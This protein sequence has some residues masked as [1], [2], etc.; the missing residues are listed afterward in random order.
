MRAANDEGRVEIKVRMPVEL[1]ERLRVVTDER[2]VSA[3][4]VV[5]RALAKYLDELEALP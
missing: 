4:L 3:N 1:R 5:V 2:V